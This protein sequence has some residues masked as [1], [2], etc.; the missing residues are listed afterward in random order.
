[1]LPSFSDNYLL[2]IFCWL[3]FWF[4]CQFLSGFF[5]RAFVSK[6]SDSGRLALRVVSIIH[7]V[8]AVAEVFETYLLRDQMF[9]TSLYG[10][11]GDVTCHQ[12]YAF[13]VAYYWWDLI[14]V[15]YTQ[16]G[17]KE[18]IT[19]PAFHSI[20]YFFKE[21]CLSCIVLCRFL[22]SSFH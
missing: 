8:I 13:V 15:L 16:Y 20:T 12:W 11:E 22:H 3:V 14:T 19:L 4:F 5:V 17:K 21:L 7:A 9:P 1:M 18:R 10:N 2:N 6:G